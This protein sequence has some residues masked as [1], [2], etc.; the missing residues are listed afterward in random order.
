MSPL[1]RSTTVI[2]LTLILWAAFL[3]PLVIMFGRG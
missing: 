1:A 3:L 2:V